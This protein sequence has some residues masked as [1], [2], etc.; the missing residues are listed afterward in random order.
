MLLTQSVSGQAKPWRI[1]DSQQR[2]IA[3]LFD[4]W[5]DP[6]SPG[7]V[8]GV[9]KRGE[10]VHCEAF[11]SEDPN[12]QRPLT[13]NSVFYLASNSKQFTAAAIAILA[14]QNRLSLDDDVRKWIPELAKVTPPIKI[15][16]LVHHSSGVRDYGIMRFMRNETFNQQFG[17]QQ[18]IEL[19]A[20]QQGVNFAAGAQYA[21]SNSNYV[22]LSE[23]VTRAS[24][25]SLKQFS[26]EA[27]FSPLGMSGAQWLPAKNIR[28][29]VA[30]F[31]VNETSKDY[32]RVTVEFDG[33]GDGNLWAAVSDLARWDG[34]FYRTDNLGATT[35]SMLQ[36]G[37]LSNGKPIP[38]GFGLSRSEWMGLT[39][40]SHG[41]AMFGYR[42]SILRIPDQ[43]ICV[44]V[45]A[46]ASDVDAESLSQSVARIALRLAIA[47]REPDKTPSVAQVARTSTDLEI[48]KY[49]GRFYSR[50]L[51]THW[52]LV[53]ENGKLSTE[54][55]NFELC[56]ETIAKGQFKHD[57]FHIAFVESHR[58]IDKRHNTFLVHCDSAVGI[59]FERVASTP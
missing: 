47:P 16:D 32:K 7:A 57:L 56:F 58:A 48:T 15:S 41:G 17:N 42:S 34:A 4:R 37:K 3:R 38:Y 49:A 43:D 25:Q 35:R 26:R 19:L 27:I 53:I 31:V 44:V 50:E 13:K 39:T 46:N 11:G 10:L 36:Q 8:V 59:R 40:W 2:A 14:S 45:L 54:L 21:Y 24:K 22:L 18:T 9:I 52:D 55:C 51:D 30:S 20:R 12:T 6:D 23:V 28:E 5:N 33:H 29:K 1:G